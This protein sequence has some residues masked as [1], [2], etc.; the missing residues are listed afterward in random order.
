MK[1]QTQFEKGQFD[2]GVELAHQRNFRGVTAGPSSGTGVL[3]YAQ[4]WFGWD[5]KK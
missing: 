4:Y 3:V 2:V 5:L 1:L